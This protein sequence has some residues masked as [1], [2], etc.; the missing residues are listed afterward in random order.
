MKKTNG[1]SK[2]HAVVVA[3][4]V[5]A[6]AACA[7]AGC[8]LAVDFDRTKIDAGLPTDASLTDVV[9]DTTGG[10]NVVPDTSTDAPADTGADSGADVSTDTGVD[11]AVDAGMD[12]AM[13][14]EAASAASLAITATNT[15]V[16]GN[17]NVGTS[18]ADIVFTITNSGGTVSGTV[19][20]VTAPSASG[21]ILGGQDNCTGNT[22]APNNGTCTFKVHF[23]P[24]SDGAKSGNVTATGA[25]N[26]AVTGTGNGLV[27]T[28]ASANFMTVDGGATGTAQVFTITNNASVT[29]GAL[30]TTPGGADVAQ[31]T[32]TPDTC[33]GN[34]GVPSTMTCTVTA[35]FAPVAG[36][37]GAKNASFSVAAAGV[38]G[39]VSATLTG[40]AN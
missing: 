11:S 34:A 31:F 24:T 30:T 8:E 16:F 35:D 2:A 20:T 5:G 25:A 39:S 19:T 26:F 12:A 28:P 17:Q 33:N 23:T 38:G 21:F 4:L 9:A 22:V 40:T 14:A 7:A 10:D 15:G 37:M 13:E 3:S 29:S 36:M 18:G 1:M 32:F 27:I 6:L